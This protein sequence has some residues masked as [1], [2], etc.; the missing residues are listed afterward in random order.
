MQ[1]DK[2]QLQPLTWLEPH[3]NFF[4]FALVYRYFN[5]E[6]IPRMVSETCFPLCALKFCGS[7]MLTE[8]LA[9]APGNPT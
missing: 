9:E 5:T 2:L 4:F 8:A 3:M 7:M 1:F 6:V